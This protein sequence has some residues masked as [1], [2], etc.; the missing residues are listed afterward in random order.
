MNSVSTPWHRASFDRFLQEGLAKLLAERLPLI[1]YQAETGDPHTCRIHVT[2][3][4]ANGDLEIVFDNLPMPDEE[5][6]LL[7]G[8]TPHVV[9]PLA[10]E[11]ALDRAE[12]Y[13]IGEQLLDYID[14][15]LE[16]VPADLPW[17]IELARAWLALDLRIHAFLH[18]RAQR[19]DTTNRLSRQT[20][21][22]R[23]LLPQRGR[24]IDPGQFGRVCPFELP[25]GPNMGRV[26]TVARGA[27][28]R[29]S[30]LVIV[31]ERAEAG[32]GPVSSMIPFLEHND[33]NR[34]LMGANMLRQW[35]PQADPEPAWVQTGHE[36]G[37]ADFWNGRNLLTAFIPW[38]EGTFAS[39]IVISAS[40]ARRLSTPYP[41]EVGDKL[42]NRHGAKGVVSQ[43]LPDEEMPHL[44]DGTPVELVYNDAG[45]HTH[46]NVGQLREAVLGRIARAEGQPAI[47]PPFHA[48][49]AA[50]LHRRLR[51]AGLPESG[52]ET[53]TLGRGG[54]PLARPSTVGWVYWGRLAHLARGKVRLSVDGQS[55]QRQGELEHDALLALGAHENLREY[56]NTRSI[57]RADA[58]TLATRLAA[59]L[60][61]Q[62]PP[63][64]PMFAEL[65]RRLRAAGIEAF[66]DGNRLAFR[67]N[68]PQGEVLK[69]AQPI[70]HP[71]LQ[72]HTLEQ[73]GVL[74]EVDGYEALVEA[75]ERLGRMLASGTP[76]QLTQGA[77]T[78][79]EARLQA[80]LEALLPPELLRFSERQLFTA[81][82]VIAP[83]AGLHLDQVGLAEEIAWTLFGP[84][85]AREL[86]D[87]EAVQARSPAAG[88]ALD[89]VMARSWIIVNRAP[90]LTP[91][92]LLAFHPVR[93]PGHVIRLHPLACELLNADFD[94]DQV[95]VMLP[96]TAG[97]QREAGEKL[98]I[99]AHL[100]R[101]PELLGALLPTEDALWGLAWL[102]FSLE[103]RR[104]IAHLAGIDV[105]TPDGYLTRDTLAQALGQVLAQE[106]AR[107]ALEA[108]ERLTRRGFAAA[109]DSGGS[110]SPFPEAGLE[111][112]PEPVGD[113]P[114][115]W[116][117][118]AEELLERLAASSDFDGPLGPQLLA[119]RS[120]GH[121]L[122]Q[123]GWL[124]G[125]RGGTVQDARG[126]AVIVRHGY[127]EGLTAEEMY[128][129]VAG[130]RQA[131]AQVMVEWEHLGGEVRERN[132][133]R[134][135]NVLARA[136]RSRRPG[137][138]FARAAAS[139]EGDP[140][141]DVYGRLLVGLEVRA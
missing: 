28:I 62:A 56:L 66:L 104:E 73:V 54:P 113:D 43:V 69:L 59:G 82:A 45:L 111:R 20:H 38:G 48:P 116:E 75:N 46:M 5:G 108:L 139:G 34:V 141:T 64:T 67:W 102:S 22:R 42:S 114:E 133:P 81:R 36:P 6:V 31:D 130:A 74:P 90:S 44:P 101:A 118:Y 26:F 131:L 50:E 52:M 119:V 126:R 91:T 84:L 134:G 2:L 29:E 105:P 15:R 4:S 132:E 140:L 60:L 30:R 122:R 32:L 39:G 12:V 106:G 110:L 88:R 11:E 97:A 55:G 93:D 96:L 86:G 76:A 33:P 63:P 19:L 138:V 49:S 128:A 107:G 37:A 135:F 25:E 124:V 89:A 35:L 70:S 65:A 3:S 120:S 47:V 115:P 9:V 127:G 109:R 72:E 13:C 40:C 1:G 17:D 121:G 27:Q 95:A 112:P 125:S 117:R 14:E 98:S 85:A 137:I 80:Y 83:A 79:L 8:E 100:A 68:P 61:E 92:A 51:Q 94:G 24:V 18:E 58:D 136:R 16:P 23:I 123:L 53:L 57:R 78:Q 7:L 21:L 41:A 129:C 103:G 87:A 99:A 71:W 10:T 77:Q